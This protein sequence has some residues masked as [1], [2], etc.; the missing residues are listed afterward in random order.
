MNSS[1]EINKNNHN[2]LAAPGHGTPLK[3]KF[4]GTSDEPIIM[5]IKTVKF[6]AFG[7]NSGIVKKLRSH[8][9]MDE[10]AH[11]IE[12]LSIIPFG[13]EPKVARNI[14]FAK[15]HAKVVTDIEIKSSLP[16]KKLYVDSFTLSGKISEIAVIEEENFA[17]NEICWQKISDLKFDDDNKKVA[18]YKN[19][20]PFL[21]LLV[22]NSTGDIFEV[23]TGDDLWRWQTALT[24]N[25]INSEFVIGVD[26]KANIDVERLVLDLSVV[27]AD[28]KLESRNWRF[29]WYFAWQDAN[30]NALN[31]KELE[32]IVGAAKDLVINKKNRDLRDFSESDLVFKFTEESFDKAAY[33]VDEN[34][35]SLKAPCFEAPATIKA[36][37]KWLRSVIANVSN[38]VKTITLISQNNNLCFNASHLSRGTLKQLVH[39]DIDA[40]MDFWI[41][42]SQQCL[43]KGLNFEL[44]TLNNRGEIFDLPSLNDL[45]NGLN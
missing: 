41:W 3:F 1:I 21:V 15:N 2:I 36:S 30:C 12:M 44:V 13:S 11:S 27:D 40:K 22:K 10:S 45:A 38:D 23:G 31:N 34:S 16:V 24:K 25:S 42:A 26:E 43:K 9:T 14:N 7:E 4:T 39:L 37:R 28:N 19:E 8:E 20:K 35:Q 6:G 5:D 29:K 17:K 32:N 33:L 18:V